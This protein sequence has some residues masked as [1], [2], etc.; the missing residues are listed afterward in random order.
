MRISMK[1]FPHLP[2]LLPCFVAACLFFFSAMQ[3][4]AQGII[5]G[6]LT[7][8]VA[9]PSGAVIP[10]ASVVAVNN[11]TK[12]AFKTVSGSDGTFTMTDLPIGT[13]TV[14]FTAV[15]FSKNTVENAQVVT[16]LA[17]SLN[18][19]ILQPGVFGRDGAGCGELRC[20]AGHY[21][22]GEF[23]YRGIEGA[24]GAAC[25]WRLRYHCAAGARYRFYA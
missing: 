25:V 13:Y 10:N 6:G 2:A 21:D 22:V 15:G 8:F 16:G 9:D 5:T 12:G 20:T 17:T 11:N 7:G 19:R 23:G 24:A 3:A 4:L 14:T 18:N 1:R